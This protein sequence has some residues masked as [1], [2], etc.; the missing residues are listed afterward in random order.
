MTFWFRPEDVVGVIGVLECDEP[1]VGWG[2]VSRSDSVGSLDAE[3]VDV[4]AGGVGLH[5]GGEVA[6]PG[7]VLGVLRAVLP[8]RQDREVE[9]GVAVTEGGG[10]DALA[11]DRAPEMLEVERRLWRGHQR[12]VLQQRG[13]DAV[14]DLIDVMRLPV[15]LLTIWIS[16]VRAGLQRRVGHRRDEVCQGAPKAAQRPQ[17]SLA[18][19]QVARPA[20]REHGDQL[21]VHLRRD[22]AGR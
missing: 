18:G 20:H 22:R 17:R 12:H 7:E 2:R 4:D 3:V 5:R 11:A 15:V 13:D 10:V 6:R 19:G 9:R 8:D 21:A 16:R 14:G 1:L